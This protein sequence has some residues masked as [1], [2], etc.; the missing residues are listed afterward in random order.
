MI[1]Q[2]EPQDVFTI[3]L[4]DKFCETYLIEWS[5]DYSQFHFM[6]SQ[7][8]DLQVVK[9]KIF[10]LVVLLQFLKEN[11]YI[12]VFGAELVKDNKI[13]NRN[14]YQ[15][16]GSSWANY[17]LSELSET[18]IESTVKGLSG[19]F[20]RK[21]LLNNIQ[22]HLISSIGKEIEEFANSSYHVTQTL[23]DIV[24]NDFQTE[25]DKRYIQS[26]RQA[27]I[28][29]WVS[30]I[31]GLLSIN[32]DLL[33]KEYEIAS[34]VKDFLLL[35]NWLLYIGLLLIIAYLLYVVCLKAKA[36]IYSIWNKK[37]KR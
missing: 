24:N 25:E 4:F 17:V 37:F 28:A 13:Y 32:K 16:D 14:K 20:S 33:P 21:I 31:V 3:T 8:S 27:W 36:F 11:R 18:K 19:N 1:N 5:E 6:A 30:V 35:L 29:I 26:N 2:H 22:V 23:V 9:K 7:T 10:D 34:Y 15:L 12:G